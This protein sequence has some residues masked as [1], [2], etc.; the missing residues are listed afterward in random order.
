M[1]GISIFFLF[2][3]CSLLLFSQKDVTTVGLQFK[4]IIP[5]SYLNT[6]RISTSLNGIDFSIDQKIGYSFGMLVRRGYTEQISLEFGINYTR[7]NYDLIIEDDENNFRGE[8]DFTY[9]IYEFPIQGLVY[10]KLTDELYMNV[11]MG[12]AL[13]ILPTNWESNDYYFGHLSRKKS[14]IIP[15]LLANV[16]FEYRTRKS[17]YF[18]LGA[19][20]HRPFMDITQAVVLYEYNG[21]S[22]IVGMDVNGN[23]LTVDLRYFFHERAERR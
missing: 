3:F 7:R 11:A 9:I 6:G 14:W 13:D 10:V 23:Y 18:Y 16:G 5:S 21:R 2:F 1:K 19:S 4:P 17:G 15:A 8:S 12:G 22:E 20:F